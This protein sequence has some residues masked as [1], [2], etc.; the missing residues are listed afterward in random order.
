MYNVSNSISPYA[1]CTLLYIITTTVLLVGLLPSSHDQV[2]S[3]KIGKSCVF[4][5][6][7]E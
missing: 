2:K 3:N 1:L 5:P 7:I 4:C 6:T